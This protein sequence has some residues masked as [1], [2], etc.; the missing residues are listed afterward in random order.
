MREEA[1][2]GPLLT[3]ATRAPGLAA[4]SRAPYEQILRTYLV[5]EF[6]AR[7]VSA[8]TREI[9]KRYFAGLEAGGMAP[10]TVRKV[11]TVLSAVLSEAVELEIIKTNPA[12]RALRGRPRIEDREM[13]FLDGAEVA[14]LADAIVPH[15]R[16]LVLTAAYT[17]LRAS[18]LGGCGSGTWTSGAASSTSASRSSSLRARTRRPAGVTFGDLKS[19]KSR[20]TVALPR[21]LRAL[22]AEHA[23]GRTGDELVFVTTTGAPIRH[24][25]FYRRCFRPAVTAALPAAKHG[26]R[27][28][29][30]RHT[31]AAMLVSTG[32]HPKVVSEHLGH[33][34]IAITMDRYGH[35]YE[36]VHAAT[37]DA[38]DALWTRLAPP[39]GVHTGVRGGLS[40]RRMPR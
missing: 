23:A 22:L 17:G 34:S 40:S 6:G 28:H 16:V 8:L 38:L 12:A 24:N 3:R 13:L 27:F 15:Y 7:R 36:G 37:A 19:R 30:L 32:A 2:H 4:K 29:D 39:L 11:H 21:F 14:A 33:G 5:P 10:G 18:E 9:V 20:R 1:R 31:Y 26:L 25:L 35:L